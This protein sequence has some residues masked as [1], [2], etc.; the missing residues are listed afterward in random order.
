[1]GL[2]G[3]LSV[4]RCT[5]SIP[6][7]PGKETWSP[8]RF[9]RQLGTQRLLKH[10]AER[11]ERYVTRSSGNRNQLSTQ[12]GRGRHIRNICAPSC[13][14]RDVRYASRTHARRLPPQG[15]GLKFNHP[16]I[17]PCRRRATG[18]P[19]RNRRRNDAASITLA[20]QWSYRFWKLRNSVLDGS[21]GC[22]QT[23]TVEELPDGSGVGV[24]KSGRSGSTGILVASV[25]KTD[26]GA[27]RLC[28]AAASVGP[29]S[30]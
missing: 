17:L 30:N 27:L 20:Q 5:Y 8:R 4:R 7:R 29:W 26:E 28:L 25:V 13:R 18:T 16:K 12:Q 1:V 9:G 6:S 3:H 21:S 10:P 24:D 14:G 23:H 15:E 11:N 2:S 22:V 19:H